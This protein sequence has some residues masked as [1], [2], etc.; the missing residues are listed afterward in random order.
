M[1]TKLKKDK[2][3]DNSVDDQLEAAKQK[4]KALEDEADGIKADLA[5][6]EEDAGQDTDAE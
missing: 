2:K 1:A 5:R 3:G 4:L 6:E